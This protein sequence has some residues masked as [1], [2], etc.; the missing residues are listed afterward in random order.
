MVPGRVNYKIYQGTTFKQVYRWETNT[1]YYANIQSI[2]KSGPCIITTSAPHS[3]P[4]GWRVRVTNVGGMKEINVTSDDQY[5][6]VNDA[7]SNTLT[8]NQINSSGFTNYT[9]GGTVE[10]NAPYPLQYYSAVM[11]IRPTATSDTIILSRN[12]SAGG[13]IVIDP[14]T[15]TITVTI[16]A[17]QTALFDFTVAVYGIELTDTSGNVTPFLTGNITLVKDVIR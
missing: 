5:Y 6:V 17:T 1:K 13:G 2:T 10:Y 15:S 11:Q 16:T 8:I 12:S 9:S 3:I 14:V 4:P 7:T